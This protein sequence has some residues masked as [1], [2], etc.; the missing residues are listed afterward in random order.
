MKID[1]RRFGSVAAG[2]GRRSARS[3]APAAIGRAVEEFDLADVGSGGFQD[4]SCTGLDRRRSD[5]DTDLLSGRDFS[6]HL[7]IDPA[8]GVI[9]P[10]S[11]SHSAASSARC[12]VRLPFGGHESPFGLV[13]FLLSFIRPFPFP[14]L[15]PVPGELLVPTAGSSFLVPK[16]QLGNA[17]PPPTGS[18]DLS[19]FAHHSP[20]RQTRS[21]SSASPITRAIRMIVIRRLMSSH[22]RVRNALPPASG[23]CVSG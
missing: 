21:I 23:P 14:T 19:A 6:H 10:A 9:L 13:F 2:G 12:F 15:S 4:A 11:P 1:D 5:E 17:L 8:D 18:R 3:R 7:A 22:F 20:S 16:L